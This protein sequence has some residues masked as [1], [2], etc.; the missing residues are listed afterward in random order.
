[1]WLFAMFDL[2]V[3]TAKARKRYTEFRKLLLEQGFS[4]LQYSV[5]ARY[6][7]SEEMA[8]AYRNRIRAR[9]RRRGMSACWRS[10]TAS[11]AKWR[12]TLEKWANRLKNLLPN[13]CFSRLPVALRDCGVMDYARGSVSERRFPASHSRVVTR[14]LDS[15]RVYPSDDSLQATAQSWLAVASCRSVSE[16]RFPASHSQLQIGGRRGRKCIR[17]TIPRKPQRSRRACLRIRQCIRA[18]IPRKPQRLPVDQSLTTSSVSE[19]RFP[20]S[21]SAAAAIRDRRIQCIR[22]TI[23]C[24]PQRNSQA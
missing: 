6:C 16:R 1:M 12:V 15:G 20:A 19:R 11:S 10:L 18:T 4:M 17:A 3:T 14:P 8:V 7:A 5:Y 2:P 9:C 24:K 22:A 23:P 13:S 21:H